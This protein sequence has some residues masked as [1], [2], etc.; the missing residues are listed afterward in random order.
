MMTDRLIVSSFLVPPGPA[1]VG[2][3]D[4][5]SRVKYVP[6]G[7]QT[8][9]AAHRPQLKRVAAMVR[10]RP[11]KTRK[12]SI[13]P[14]PPPYESPDH[15]VGAPP[16]Y[17]VLPVEATR[18][19]LGY[20]NPCFESLTDVKVDNSFEPVYSSVT[21][22][23]LRE[24]RLG[25]SSRPDEDDEADPEEAMASG[26][27]RGGGGGGG[28]AAAGVEQMPTSWGVERV[29]A[30]APLELQPLGAA[31]TRADTAEEESEKSQG[32]A[33]S[34]SVSTGTH[35][36]ALGHI[37]PMA[38]LLWAA[39]RPME[40]AWDL[41]DKLGAD[42]EVRQLVEQIGDAAQQHGCQVSRKLY[43]RLSLAIGNVRRERE[44]GTGSSGAGGG[45][46]AARDAK[47][48]AGDSEVLT[49][50]E[51]A[52]GAARSPAGTPPSFS[53]ASTEKRGGDGTSDGSH[54]RDD[55]DDC[56]SDDGYDG[57]S[58]DGTSTIDPAL[59]RRV[60]DPYRYVKEV[61]RQWEQRQQVVLK[62]IISVKVHQWKQL[63]NRFIRLECGPDEARRLADEVKTRRRERPIGR[64]T[65]QGGGAALVLGKEW[66]ALADAGSGGEE[67]GERGTREA[68]GES[69]GGGGIADGD[70]RVQAE[71]TPHSHNH[72][73]EILDEA[74]K[75]KRKEGPV[76]GRV[77]RILNLALRLCNLTSMNKYRLF[78]S[79][80]AS[81]W[82]DRE[83]RRRLQ[84]P[85]H[86]GKELGLRPDGGHFWETLTRVEQ[87]GGPLRTLSARCHNLGMTRD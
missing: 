56:S 82:V 51:A 33:A 50:L 47:R 65:A 18:R 32:V 69:I 5:C 81:G 54:S 30:D 10:F 42:P 43:N 49:K 53:P 8:S 6:A 64:T 75:V 76:S 4:A 1:C 66:R 63:V 68:A 2:R 55:E 12:S 40:P 13:Y 59:R 78:A 34:P 31:E 79:L 20:P 80:P 67:E 70:A 22:T 52:A 58:L 37:S 84:Q 24:S 16:E 72:T 41:L 19:I 11:R 38:K 14:A 44:W 26:D 21:G 15:Y 83:M 45:G 35:P 73:R 87:V 74:E 23:S 17:L 39:T 71:T 85:P 29:T 25:G 60:L 7:P 61:D 77:G 48:E 62:Q 86:F 46:A 27:E 36:P 3:C 57:S 9:L 28:R